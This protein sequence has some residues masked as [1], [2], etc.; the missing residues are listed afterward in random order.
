VVLVILH[1]GKN[2]NHCI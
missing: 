2:I 1:T